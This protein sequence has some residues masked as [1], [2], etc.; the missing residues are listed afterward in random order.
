MEEQVRA[1]SSPDFGTLLRQ[2]RLAAGLSQEALAERARMSTNGIGALERGYRRTPQ[3]ETLELLAGALALDGDQRRLFEA[4]AARSSTHR[5]QGGGSVTVGPWPGSDAANLPLALTSFFGR[6]TE[7][8]EVAAL[9]R[10]HRL[11][12]LTGSG[13]IGKTQTAL[14]VARE[15]G[16]RTAN[17]VRFVALSPVGKPS[18]VTPAIASALGAQ[19]LPD[20]SVLETL[21][22]HLSDKTL[23]L[24]LDNCE[25]V[26]DEV[27]AVAGA[28]LASCP[29]IRVLATSR[30]P[31]RTAGERI[32]R[33]PSLSTQEAVAL[34]TDR[35]LAVDH[36]FAADN[37][38]PRA[39]SEICRHLDG[40]PLAIELAAARVAFLPVKALSE[41]L[42][43]R[44][45][46]LS[47][48]VRAALPRHQTM[49]AT[50]NWS[51]DL[52]SEQ[53][54]RLFDRL[55]IFSGG[56]TLDAAEAV[57][58][59]E[60]LS[61]AE[62]FDTLWSLAEKSLVVADFSEENP[63]YAMLE[64][65]RLFAVQNLA[66]TGAK[67]D[68]ARRHAEWAATLGDG[69]AAA[70]GTMGAP[71]PYEL[72][73]E[74]DNARAA[75]DWAL[76]S[77]EISLA[78]RIACGFSV[79]WRTN[80][81]YSEPRGWLES[82]LAAR[83]WRGLAAV[84]FAMRRV[85]AARRA[86]A[87]GSEG[88]TNDAALGLYQMSIGLLQAGR[89]EEAEDVNARALRI[90]EGGEP[91]PSAVAA[92]L[93]VRGTIASM[94]GHIEDA[95]QYYNRALSV[96]TDVG[97]EFDAIVVRGNI[98]ELEFKDGRS[99]KALELA[100]AALAASRRVC[101]KYREVTALLNVTAY[102]LA[103]GR[104]DEAR[105]A[106]NDTLSLARG[107]HPIFVTTAIQHSA[108]VAALGGDASRAAR[109]FGYVDAWYQSHEITR[110]TTEQ[111]T[112][113]ILLAALHEKLL[114]SEVASLAAQGARLSEEE[115]VTE[116]LSP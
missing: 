90:C 26:I 34:F 40:I 87:L 48:G 37:E 106:A 41:R 14:R 51:Y 10:G 39:L 18:L 25:H 80:R 19:E 96:A 85:E 81:G 7:L 9:V 74:L 109:L 20:R 113:E 116:A 76:S 64:S 15:Y 1:P 77:R 29:Q 6:E 23:L 45:R 115:A 3:R 43:E 65:T 108:A 12:T 59:D 112:Y 8:R 114:E 62:I 11:V 91:T 33:L 31:L 111:R 50:I 69:A 61:V 94:R 27:S 24:V 98:G 21:L 88:D 79:A 57:A 78:A 99:E 95:R 17:G 30:E 2:H 110:Y 22:A 107:T 4:A 54:R 32:Y 63:R 13:G 100:E 82:V 86:L 35:A 53:E 92:T 36:R 103:L 60:A 97:D 72:E 66:Q 49:W 5:R 58:S 101:W 68:L 73:L 38:N 89:L 102:R 46:I 44:F 83:A 71:L 75:L 52:L 42:N 93:D 84:S 56:W 47:G 67:N 28:L 70:A 105:S 104:I 16:E 55:S